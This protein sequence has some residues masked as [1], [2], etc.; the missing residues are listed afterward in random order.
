[1]YLVAE[2]YHAKKIL[3]K[4]VWSMLLNLISLFDAQYTD[5][6]QETKTGDTWK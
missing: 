3:Q 5:A 1:M 6:N 4:I 2:G